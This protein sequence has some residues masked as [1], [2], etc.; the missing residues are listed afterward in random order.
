MRKTLSLFLLFLCS[1][2]IVA[3]RM[4]KREFRGAWVQIINGQ[5]QGLGRD[6]M[7]AN[8]TRQLDA[9]QRAGINVVMFQVR[10]EADAMYPS[11]YEPWSRFLTGRQGTPP[12]PYWDPLEWMIEQCHRRGMEL[13]AWINPFRAKTKTTNELSTTHPY[14]RD[15]KRFFAYDGLLL[16]D[17]ARPENRSYICQVAADIVRRYDVDGLHIDDYFYPYPVAGLNI[18]DDASFATYGNGFSDRND[19]RRHN[20]NLFI[21]ELHDTLRAVK[22]WVKFGV[23]P[24]GIYHN[25]RNGTAVPGS[26]TG[27]LQNYD[28]LYADIL[29]WI[30]KG[31][32]DYNVPQLYWEIGHKTADYEHLVHWW[33]KH[34]T[35]R[36]L[37]IGQDIERTMRAKDLQDASQSQL[38][39]KMRIADSEP[40][41]V[42][43]CF[44]YSAALTRNEGGIGD[45]LATSYQSRPALL[46]L[47]PFIDKHAPKK[48]RKVKVM[49]MEDAP[50]LFWS[51]PKA[52][53]EMDRA[54]R[55]VVYRF[56]K[57]ES[58]DLN[59]AQNIVA[60]TDQTLLRLP[61]HGGAT[62]YT[63]IV[64]S[65]DRLHNESKGK[66][67][68]IKL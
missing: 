57:G 1:L 16:F 35:G 34:A 33:A 11:P 3:Q 18:P 39:A 14:L 64:T 32:I 36:P 27:G 5:F 56:A 20:V 12:T 38:A 15:P 50:Y 8:L 30:E 43:N 17:P 2:T 21:Q 26:Q 45:A 52:K 23:S 68:T 62:K 7:Q 66:K 51:A 58:I 29:L 10:G 42:G 47:M 37:I 28:D 60:I 24:F 40:S 4:P 61:Y 22:P 13:H 41:V 63:Y 55:Y 19:W 44:W 53:K 48:P 65:L 67:K 54:V 49:D 31:W 9:M 46:P 6:G 59:K 25:Q